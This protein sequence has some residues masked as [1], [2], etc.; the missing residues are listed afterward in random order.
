[1]NSIFGSFSQS[2]LSYQVVEVREGLF[3]KT[4]I[5]LLFDL[6]G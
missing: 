5:F 2:H 1:M 3:S 4:K 6:S